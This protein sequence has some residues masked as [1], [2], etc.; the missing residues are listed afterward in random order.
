MTL[1]DIEIDQIM[2]KIEAQRAMNNRFFCD[3]LRLTFKCPHCGPKAKA[4]QA[5]IRTGDKK[6]TE[7]NELL[8]A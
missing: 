8:C 2:D 3:W 4:L 5:Q 6:I 7:M 1:R